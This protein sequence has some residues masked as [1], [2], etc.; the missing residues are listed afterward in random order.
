[1]IGKIIIKIDKKTKTFNWKP[2]YLLLN[3]IFYIKSAPLQN[4][5]TNKFK[6]IDKTIL[7]AAQTDLSWENAKRKGSHNR[8]FDETKHYTEPCINIEIHGPLVFPRLHNRLE[9]R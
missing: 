6:N 9:R 5:T 1:M 2:F 3:N 8:F 7:G 4:S